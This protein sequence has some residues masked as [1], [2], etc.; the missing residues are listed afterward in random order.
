[1]NG[2]QTLNRA[3]TYAA[4]VGALAGS[5]LCF[6][7]MALI[8]VDVTIRALLNNAIPGVVELSEFGLV[9]IAFFAQA[10]AYSEGR[11]I[12]IDFFMQSVRPGM[13]RALEFAMTIV[14]LALVALMASA[15]VGSGIEMIEGNEISDTLELQKGWFK[16][17]AG[18]GLALLGLAMIRRLILL[19]QRA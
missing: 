17:A 1:M 3:L 18:I 7:M 4:R 12:S 13:A 5:G 10:S 6:A 8:A 15:T 14:S 16:L 11:H 2:G 9:L 19:T